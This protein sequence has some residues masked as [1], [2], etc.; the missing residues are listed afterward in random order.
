[1]RADD[2]DES[3]IVTFAKTG[4]Y[5]AFDTVHRRNH[6]PLVRYLLSKVRNLQTAEDIAQEAWSNVVKALR[7]G[8]YQAREDASFRTYLYRIAENCRIDEFRR[9]NIRAVENVPVED[10]DEASDGSIAGDSETN[11]AS[12]PAYALHQKRLLERF[13]QFLMSLPLVQREAASLYYMGLSREEIAERTGVS[14][15]TVK[16]RLRH[17]AYKMDAWRVQQR[18]EL[19]EEYG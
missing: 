18:L 12:D 9:N 17:M 4:E 13:E 1:M 8:S 16:T 19:G 11:L 14:A 2:S 5:A 15:E 6:R 3:L 10:C 7:K